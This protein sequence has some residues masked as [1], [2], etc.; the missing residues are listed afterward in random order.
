MWKDTGNQYKGHTIFVDD[1]GRLKYVDTFGESD[2]I[3]TTVPPNDDG[4]YRFTGPQ[5]LSDPAVSILLAG[6]TTLERLGVK[7]FPKN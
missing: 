1:D 7:D 5:L 4:V 3:V 2:F 6:E